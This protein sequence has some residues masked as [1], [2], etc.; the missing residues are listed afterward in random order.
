MKVSQLLTCLVA[1]QAISAASIPESNNS[2]TLLD[3]R[4]VVPATDIVSPDHKLERRRGRGV[5]GG[6][7]SSSGGG[8]SGRSASSMNLRVGKY[9]GYYAVGVMVL[10]GVFM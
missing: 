1:S 8:G 6:R 2:L 10:V 5:T 3:G 4:R 7:S 9:A